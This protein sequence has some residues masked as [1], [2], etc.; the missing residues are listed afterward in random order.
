MF[1]ISGESDSRANTVGPDA[2]SPALLEMGENSDGRFLITPYK[3]IDYQLSFA[4]D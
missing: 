3:P 2:S 1:D 4:V